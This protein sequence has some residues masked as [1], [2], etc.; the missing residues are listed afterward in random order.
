MILYY[1][2]VF[3]Q[4]PDTIITEQVLDRIS[5]HL[6]SSEDHELGYRIPPF[7]DLVGTDSTRYDT[8]LPTQEFSDCFKRHNPDSPI[9]NKIQEMKLKIRE[10]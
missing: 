5:A 2:D 4:G 3:P 10:N 1:S 9:L 8:K 6:N 7:K